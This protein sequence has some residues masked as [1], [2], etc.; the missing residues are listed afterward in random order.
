MS[1]HL[2]I[3]QPGPERATKRSVS[4]ASSLVEEVERRIGKKGFSAVVA[5]ALEQWLAMAKLREVIAMDRAE[6]GPVPEDVMR[7]VEAEWSAND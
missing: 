5:E 3:P 6:F 4:L 1:T 7:R 2:S